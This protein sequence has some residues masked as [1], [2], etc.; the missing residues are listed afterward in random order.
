[1]KMFVIS[2]IRTKNLEVLKYQP[3]HLQTSWQ[4]HYYHCN[5]HF[6][7]LYHCSWQNSP[8]KQRS[9]TMLADRHL[10]VNSNQLLDFEIHFELR[11][12]WKIILNQYWTGFSPV[13]SPVGTYSRLEQYLFEVW[14]WFPRP[15][16]S[17]WRS[18]TQNCLSAGHGVDNALKDGQLNKDSIQKDCLL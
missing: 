10:N 8:C 2:K 13:L 11:I 5:W 14:I 6:Q 15:I 9:M 12:F 7:L 1:M 18:V 17:T 3:C 16:H 4:H